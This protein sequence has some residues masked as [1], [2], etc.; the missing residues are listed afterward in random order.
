[1]GVLTFFIGLLVA[2]LILGAISDAVSK[3]REQREVKK[4]KKPCQHCCKLIHKE[5]TTCPY[6]QKDP[7][8][9]TDWSLTWTPEYKIKRM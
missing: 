6:C 5:A 9:V 2:A 7:G 3:G 1:M 4:I 8:N